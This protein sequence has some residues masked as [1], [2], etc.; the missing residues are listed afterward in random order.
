MWCAADV[1]VG[2]SFWLS[3]SVSLSESHSQNLSALFPLSHSLWVPFSLPD[4]LHCRRKID[5]S[6]SEFGSSLSLSLS[7]YLSLSHSHK[8]TPPLENR[9]RER[10]KNPPSF[11]YIRNNAPLLQQN[12][13]RIEIGMD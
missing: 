2:T 13:K 4:T 3:E 9:W 1:L 12:A 8:T 11:F 6:K 7:L 10:T 5:F